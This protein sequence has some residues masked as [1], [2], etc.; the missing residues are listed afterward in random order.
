MP[1]RK[2]RGGGGR[3]SRKE[4]REPF[5]DLNMLEKLKRA[6]HALRDARE[7]DMDPKARKEVDL[8]M[9]LVKSA[10]DKQREREEYEWAHGR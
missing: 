8:A 5:D 2:S 9:A 1:R 6:L 7:R 3:S 4:R 10:R